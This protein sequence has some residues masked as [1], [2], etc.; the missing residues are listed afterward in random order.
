MAKNAKIGYL[1]TD[2]KF[3]A[4]RWVVGKLYVFGFMGY[5]LAPFALFSDFWSI[6]RSLYY[7]GFVLFLGWIC[8]SPFVMPR[9]IRSSRNRREPQSS[10]SSVTASSDEHQKHD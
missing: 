5:C 9:L 6:Y 4:L 10:P 7:M 3:S 2:S 1:L 8:V